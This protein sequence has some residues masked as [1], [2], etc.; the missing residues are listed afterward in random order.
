M[1][2]AFNA[3]K[4]M[5]EHNELSKLHRQMH[6]ETYS[7]EDLAEL[8]PRHHR[9]CYTK[10]LKKMKSM[11]VAST[12]N[13]STT[14]VDVCEEMEHDSVSDAP[15]D[16]AESLSTVETMSASEDDTICSEGSFRHLSTD[17]FTRHVS[18]EIIG[19][20]PMTSSPRKTTRIV[21]Q[22]SAQEENAYKVPRTYLPSM[23][24]RTFMTTSCVICGEDGS[25][26]STSSSTDDVVQG[27]AAN[28]DQVQTLLMQLNRM[29]VSF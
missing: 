27:S 5:A 14:D 3:I 11:P 26:P 1:S 9:T 16:T 17:N 13:T 10:F 28:V 18:S 2:L 19:T 6:M 7:V 12:P 8:A 22:C 15:T 4:Y 23:S 24:A 29:K 20:G 25:G 21:F